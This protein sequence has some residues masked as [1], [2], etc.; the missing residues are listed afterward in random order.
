M[1]TKTAWRAS[2]LPSVALTGILL[3]VGYH[4]GRLQPLINIGD[5]TSAGSEVHSLIYT[6]VSSDDNTY[7]GNLLQLTET[8][9]GKLCDYVHFQPKA[10][11]SNIFWEPRRVPGMHDTCKGILQTSLFDAPAVRQPPPTAIPEPMRYTYTLG[12]RVEVQDLYMH[13]VYAGKTA[14]RATWSV[15]YINSMIDRY[16]SGDY[17]PCS[18]TTGSASMSS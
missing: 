16:N 9:C 17:S 6:D 1:T 4:L 15:D 13:Q 3:L 12:G 11:V 2:A 18:Y 10:S 5:A 8:V 14:Q 7:Y